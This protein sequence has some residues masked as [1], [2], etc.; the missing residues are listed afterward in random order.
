MSL[1]S[2]VLAACDYGGHV[3]MSAVGPIDIDGYVLRGAGRSTVLDF[4]GCDPSAIAANEHACI[5]LR[6]GASLA[7]CT[8]IGLSN[9]AGTPTA[10]I[11]TVDSDG[12]RIAGVHA[13]GGPHACISV[14]GGR[15]IMIDN[16]I[17]YEPAG[18]PGLAY[19]LALEGCRNVTVVGGRYHGQRHGIAMGNDPRT[20]GTIGTSSFAEH[21]TVIGARVSS[22]SVYAADMHPGTSHNAYVRCHIDGGASVAGHNNAVYGG[23]ITPAASGECVH[24]HSLES[25]DVT[26]DGVT[27]RGVTHSRAAVWYD[28]TPADEVH[29]IGGMVRIVDC[30]IDVDGTPVYLRNRFTGQFSA[31]LARN[32]IRADAPVR[33]RRWAS[34][35]DYAGL[36]YPAADL[37]ERVVTRDNGLS[38]PIDIPINI[39]SVI[40]SAGDYSV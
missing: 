39:S 14:R 32:V 38:V 6:G 1:H 22:E 28:R 12:T 40:D 31:L 17:A 23:H 2:S 21:C 15:D 11:R 5:V 37:W 30:D 26:I 16:C 10:A 29:P 7:D 19:G 8:V 34:Y 20:G 24:L 36:D 18:A 33:V 27:M 4:R 25:L 3:D 35:Q 13:S 9:P